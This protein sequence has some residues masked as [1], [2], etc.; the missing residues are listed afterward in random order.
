MDRSKNAGALTAS[1]AMAFVCIDTMA[2]LASPSNQN[3]QTQSDFIA[4]VDSYLKGHH[5]QPYK[6]RGIDVY[7]ARC[8]LLHTFGSEVSFHKKYPDAKIFCYSDGGLHAYDPTQN[9]RLVV[10]GTASFLNDVRNAVAEF[11]KACSSD[12]EL[13]RRAEGRL[14]RLMN[15]LPFNSD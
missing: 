15:S 3:R 5:D 2:F 14:P 10:L 13:K 4:W 7:G 11:L 1:L 12:V 9:E 8:A 6:Y